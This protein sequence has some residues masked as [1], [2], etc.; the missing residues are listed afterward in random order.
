MLEAG[1][2]LAVT[3]WKERS[4]AARRE[5]GISPGHNPWTEQKSVRLRGLSGTEREKDVL[6][7]AFAQALAHHPDVSAK[8]LVKGL[9]CDVS[10]NCDGASGI[11]LKHHASPQALV[12]IHLKRIAP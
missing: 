8:D 4:L 11:V 2:A 3:K 9:W 12:P 5:L 6:N 1:K 7:I 10:Q